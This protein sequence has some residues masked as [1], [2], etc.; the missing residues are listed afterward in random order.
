MSLAFDLEVGNSSR[1]RGLVAGL[2][3]I[4]AAALMGG[5]ALVWNSFGWRGAS[6][7]TGGVLAGG[8]ALAILGWNL[9]RGLRVAP[10]GT[11][12]IDLRGGAR[13]REAG[14]ADTVPAAATCWFSLCGLVWIEASIAGRRVWLV[15]G[16]DRCSDRDWAG[17]N[18]WLRWLE[19]GPQA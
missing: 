1:I 14:A 9:V 12:S 11:L 16:R 18:R 17:L 19:R 2:H 10:R 13:W 7:T 5:G 4:A 8:S 15:S 3:L 6:L